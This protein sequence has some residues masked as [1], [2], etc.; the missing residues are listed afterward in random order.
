MCNHL[1]GERV[2]SDVGGK[3]GNADTDSGT[4]TYLGLY[5]THRSSPELPMNH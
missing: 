2:T 3:P 4:D 1:P 5:L